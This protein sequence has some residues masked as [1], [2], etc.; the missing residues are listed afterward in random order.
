MKNIPKLGDAL[1]NKGLISRQQQEKAIQA[2]QKHP[3][4]SIGEIVNKL[5]SSDK[6]VGDF[7]NR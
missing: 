7:R 5:A 1:V 3:S 4:K 2:Q 6:S